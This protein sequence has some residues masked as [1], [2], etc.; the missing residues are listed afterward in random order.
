M[1]SRVLVFSHGDMVVGAK[2]I[3]TASYT[4]SGTTVT[5]NILADGDDNGKP[6]KLNGSTHVYIKDPNGNDYT[7]ATRIQGSRTLMVNPTTHAICMPPEPPL[8]PVTLPAYTLRFRFSMSGYNPTTASDHSGFSFKNGHTWTQ[9]LDSGYND[10]DYTREDSNWDDEFNG[11][12]TNANNL[13]DIIYAGDM[14]GVTSMKNVKYLS[15]KVDGG[16]FGSGSKNKSCSIR[17]ICTFDS[18]NVTN[19]DG[20]CFHCTHMK[21][22]PEIDYSH[23]TSFWSAFDG[24]TGLAYVNRMD[25]SSAV[26]LRAIFANCNLKQLPDMSTVTSSLNLCQYAFQGNNNCGI[27]GNPGIL[28]AYNYLSAAN[29]GTKN[30]CFS[31]TGN[32]TT[33]GRAE[34]NQIPDPWKK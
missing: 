11:L 29:P 19:M 7:G 1:S 9:V 22:A 13:V 25:F 32:A 10:W 14:T 18:S 6:Y 21:N 23:S 15:G 12:F 28:A 26:S 3:Y 5:T 2:Y 34:L 20:L 30:A 33:D 17:S 8:P 24:C 4:D 31:G 16:T 27:N